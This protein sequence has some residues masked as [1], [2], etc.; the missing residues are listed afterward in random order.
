VKNFKLLDPLGPFSGIEYRRTTRVERAIS[1][2]ISG[3]NNQ[4]QLFQEWTWTTSF[5]LHGC[6]Y[7]SRHECEI[8]AWITMQVGEPS[9]TAKIAATRARV[10]SIHASNSARE[11]YQIGIELETP[12]NIW[13]VPSPPEDW[14]RGAGTEVAKAQSSTA[15]VPVRDPTIIK[16]SLPS[17]ER[18]READELV[19]SLEGK[20]QLAV[21]K[22][23]QSALASHLESAVTKAISITLERMDS[24]VLE[25]ER[26]LSARLS[27][28]VSRATEE[29]EDAATG[30][31]ERGFKRLVEDIK[32]KTQE[33]AFQ[34]EDRAEEAR[35]IL[36][37]ATNSALDEFRHQAEVHARL[38]I[39]HT[40]RRLASSLAS[41]D[42]EN[43]GVCEARLRALKSEIEQTGK[44]FTDQ[45]RHGLKAFF[46]SCLVDAISAIEQQSKA[47]FDGLTQKNENSTPE[48]SSPSAVDEKI[49]DRGKKDTDFPRS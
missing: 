15:T 2:I 26:R 43:R 18:L 39:S 35:S 5:N 23:V 41:I 46:H 21:D 29:F 40:R 32:V 19:A 16:M 4:G 1:L 45:F 42:A 28:T 24:T 12:G 14:L 27:E 38:A 8:G 17:R 13:E 9:G 34:V 48:K 31:L 47:T 25:I 49:E 7:P 44:E 6:R 3:Q 20:L 22:A 30:T 11:S 10:K 36:E 33:A 37:T